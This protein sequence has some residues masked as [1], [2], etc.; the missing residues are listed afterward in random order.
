MQRLG[1]FKE[2]KNMPVTELF[3]RGKMKQDVV[4]E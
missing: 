1:M 2:L 4:G 3:E